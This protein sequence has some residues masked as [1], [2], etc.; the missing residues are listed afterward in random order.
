M[1]GQFRTLRSSVNASNSILSR[2]YC[3]YHVCSNHIGPKVYSQAFWLMHWGSPSP[4]R[5]KIYSNSPRV[6]TLDRGVLKQNLK[7]AKTKIRTTR[8]SA[9]GIAE[10][11]AYIVSGLHVAPQYAALRAKG[12]WKESDGT[13]RFAGT[14]SL[15]DAGLLGMHMWIHTTP[16]YVHDPYLCSINPESL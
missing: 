5:T 3:S 13:E 16:L 12:R 10:V 15:K 7:Q 14:K 2:I 8:S 9:A 6:Q 1:A 11:L 4:K